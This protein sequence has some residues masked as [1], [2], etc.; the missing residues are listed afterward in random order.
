MRKNNLTCYS[1]VVVAV[2]AGGA[3]QA[4]GVNVTGGWIR[5]LPANVPAGGY[6]TLSNDSG[7]RIVLTGASS[8]G[9]GTLM[10]HK[11]ETE[12]GMAAMSDV[13]RIPVAVGAHVNF[14]PGGYHLMCIDPTTAIKPGNKVP[15]TLVLA[16]GTTV[17]SEFLVRT[18]T[19]Q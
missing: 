12:G 14:A 7:K 18:A 8:P 9:C 4:G 10:L 19:G 16:D 1:I 17:T 15:V 13:A 5:A 6:F 3:V 2:L 11:S